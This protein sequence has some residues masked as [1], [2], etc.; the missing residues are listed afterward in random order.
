[1]TDY[2]TMLTKVW[3]SLI[4]RGVS[5]TLTVA[6]GRRGPGSTDRICEQGVRATIFASSKGQP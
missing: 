5:G 4:H 6:L 1:M 3:W 2:G